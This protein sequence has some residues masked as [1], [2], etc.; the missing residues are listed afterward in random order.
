MPFSTY[1]EAIR[2]ANSTNT[3]LG[4]CVWSADEQRGYALAERL[5]AGSVFVNSWEKL[6]PSIVFGGHK[7]SGMG[8]EFGLRGLLGYCNTQAIHHYKTRAK[9]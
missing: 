7:E 8:G 4:A 2:R 5:E 3:G 6:D 1:D 9:L